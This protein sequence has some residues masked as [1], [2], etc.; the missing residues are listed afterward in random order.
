MYEVTFSAAY[1]AALRLISNG[2]TQT[3]Y[4]EKANEFVQVA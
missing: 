2:T 4:E 3:Q 1:S